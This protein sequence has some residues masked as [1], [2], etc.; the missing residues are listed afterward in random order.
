MMIIK[1]N[2]KSI[3]SIICELVNNNI[4]Q[5]VIVKTG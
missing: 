4:R 5:S 2:M 3:D 1:N